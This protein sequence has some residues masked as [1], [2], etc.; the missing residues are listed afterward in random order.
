[1]PHITVEY[2]ANLLPRIEIK[3]LLRCVHRCALDS[4]LF[5]MGAIRTR[6]IE[7][8]EYIIADDNPENAFVHIVLRIGSGRDTETRHKLGEQ[9]FSTASEFLDP[10]F[11]KIGLGLSV[12]VQV[13]DPQTA[14]RRNSLHERM[15][16]GPIRKTSENPSQR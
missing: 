7:R 13:I 9:I 1:M 12:E 6:G 15:N 10:L 8:N 11:D 14:F 4:G 5:R 2:S 3:G 16:E